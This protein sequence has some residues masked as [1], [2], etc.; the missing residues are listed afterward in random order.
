MALEDIVNALSNQCRF[1]GHVKKFYSVAEHSVRV[2]HLVERMANDLCL[3]PEE[4][5]Q[6]ALCG[7]MHDATEAYL[8]DVARP[9][10]HSRNFREYRRL[11][12]KLWRVIAKRFDLPA[13]MPK[14]VKVADDILLATEQRDLKDRPKRDRVRYEPLPETIEPWTPDDAKW[15]FHVRY[16]ELT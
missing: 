10:K 16:A 6:L 15:Q 13:K 12:D 1:I 3:E 4:V 11:E 7:L 5:R 2:S 8:N 9:V 14:I